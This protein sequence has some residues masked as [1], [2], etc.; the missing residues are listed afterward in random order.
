MSLQ[1]FINKWNGK[2]CDFDGYYGAQCVDL[3]RQYCKEVLNIPQTY[4]VKVAAEI[5]DNTMGNPNFTHIKNTPTGVPQ[6][7]DIII[8]S[9]KLNAAGHVSIFINGSVWSFNS[10]DQNF[11]VGSGC[12]IQSHNYKNVI[13]WLRPIPQLKS[14]VMPFTCFNADKDVMEAARN[15]LVKYSKGSLDASFQYKN[16]PVVAVP[17]LWTTDAQVDFIKNNPVATAFAFLSYKGNDPGHSDARTSTAPG[18]TTII[19]ASF[20]D[21]T[22]F[23]LCYE[24]IHAITLY[25]L[26][27]GQPVGMPDDVFMPDENFLIKKINTVLPFIKKLG[28]VL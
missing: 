12:H 18:S 24:M 4:P 1:E 22:P 27:H 2:K 23:N 7:G 26:D 8:W 16:I 14:V 25:L 19:I 17:T 6:A 13:G 11:P 28:G 21:I 10:F 15:L 5:W 3:Y 9:K 20:P